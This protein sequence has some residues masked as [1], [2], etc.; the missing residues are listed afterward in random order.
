MQ[1]PRCRAESREG[2]RFCT[3][4]GSS[5]EA[6]CPQC[7]FSNEPG[8]AFCGG[9][10]RS[11]PAAGAPSEP[12]FASPQTYTP[13]HLAE[14]IITS[15]AALEGERKQV[16]VLFADI[17]SSMEFI[18]DR[19]PEHARAIL[20][21]VIQRMMQALHE[22]EGTVNHVLGDGIMAL[23]GAPIGEVCLRQGDAP[24]AVP[25]LERA[26]SSAALTCPCGGRPSPRISDWPTR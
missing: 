5:L 3:R 11:L 14:Q 16:T 24:R 12:R 17:K 21:P 26:T 13:S 10:G 2:R 20:D 23:V 15:R 25:P 4:C 1:C 9:C 7:G 19:D 18:A 22:Y 8:D 6:S